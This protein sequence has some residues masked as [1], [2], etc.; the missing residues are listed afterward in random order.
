MCAKTKKIRPKYQMS[1]SVRVA[2]RISPGQMH[3]CKNDSLIGVLENYTCS[4]KS[5]CQ[6]E[7]THTHTHAR[8][9]MSRLH[10]RY[11]RGRCRLPPPPLF[12]CSVS[13]FLS[14]FC[15]FC[16]FTTDHFPRECNG[17]FSSFSASLPSSR[18]TP[19]CSSPAELSL[20]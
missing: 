14:L 11:L 6:H 17:G 8:S 19:P 1:L 5:T 20:L 12:P 9:G 16:L 4:Y 2:P 10:R 3:T 13:L 7:C 18:F 15:G